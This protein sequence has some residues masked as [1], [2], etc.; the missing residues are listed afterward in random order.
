MPTAQRCG[1]E[2][3][4]RH[5]LSVLVAVVVWVGTVTMVQAQSRTVKG[6]QSSLLDLSVR[7]RKARFD[8]RSRQGSESPEVIDH[9]VFQARG[10]S[11][12]EISRVLSARRDEVRHCVD[13]S[14]FHRAASAG[15]ISIT[16]VIEP[17]GRV[18]KITVIAFG[19]EGGSMERCVTN[20]IRR[21]RFP[22]AD[23][24]TQ[25]DYPF[26][27]GIAGGGTGHAE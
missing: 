19:S 22:L 25:V 15:E 7:A 2:V 5:A 27:L 1:K 4:M 11:Q 16:F 13:Q 6:Q 3:L 23:A 20:V 14:S 10:L 8:L 24:A 18:S 12:K 26:L 9:E 21:W 17:N